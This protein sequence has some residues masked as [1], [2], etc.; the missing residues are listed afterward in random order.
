LLA[1]GVRAVS[2]ATGPLPPSPAG[3]AIRPALGTS[4]ALPAL[5]VRVVRARVELVPLL[6]DPVRLPLDPRALLRPLLW[7]ESLALFAQ[8]HSTSNMPAYNPGRMGQDTV[9]MSRSRQKKRPASRVGSR[10]AG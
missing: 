5:R 10:E 4:A 2:P 3:A 1:P 7:S 9:R 8:A 6:L